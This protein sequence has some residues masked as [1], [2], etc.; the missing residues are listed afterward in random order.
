MIVKEDSPIFL[1]PKELSRKEILVLEGLRYSANMALL[2]YG[3]LRSDLNE[4]SVGS[5]EIDFWYSA[6]NGAWGVLDSANRFYRLLR[7]IKINEKSPLHKEWENFKKLR[8]CFHHL[9]E[10]IDEKY[11]DDHYPLFGVLTW[12][13]YNPDINPK[14]AKMFIFSPGIQ[15]G[16]KSFNPENP[17]GKEFR[18]PIDQISLTA[19]E[20]AKDK[21]PVKVEIVP[22]ISAIENTVKQLEESLNIEYDKLKDRKSVFPTDA[23]IRFDIELDE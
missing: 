17:T 19:H 1:I 21:D 3:R 20:R 16:S 18:I 5:K 13:Y 8:D 2:S 23:T 6:L 12:S 22:I 10:R 11:V 15:Q 14:F 9:D 4:I 7:A